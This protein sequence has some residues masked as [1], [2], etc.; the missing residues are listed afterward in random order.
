MDDNYT[1]FS[2]S[3]TI[4]AIK[5]SKNSTAAGP[6]GITMLHLKHIGPLGIRYLTHLFNL[7]VRAADIPALWK[8]ADIIPVPKPG[9]PLDQGTSYRPISLLCPEVKVL[10]RLNLSILKPFLSPSPSQ[11]GFKSN[12][13][14]ISAILPLATEVAR[15]FNAPKPAARTGL[16]CVDLSKAFDV[17]DIHRLLKK[18]DATYLHPN[19]K[20][21][22]C[23][24]LRDRKVRVLYQG[25]SS[26]WRKVKMGVPQGSVLSP[27]L[28][29]FLVNDITSSAPID[30]SFA[31]DFHAAF[32]DVQPSEIALDLESAALELSDQA[33]DHGLSLSAPK[34]TVTL[35]TPWNREF[36][37]LPP[38]TLEGGVIP[39]VNNPRLLGVTFDP[40]FTFSAHAA[41]IARKASSRLNVIRA[42]SDTSFGHDKECLTATFKSLVRP[43]LD[44]AA[45][46][47]FPNYSASSI[48]RLQIIQNRSLRLITGCHSASAIDHL[49]SETEILPVDQHLRLLSAQ[50]LARAL[51]PGHVSHDTVT[52]PSGPRRS[53]ETLQSKC[54][55]LVEPYLQDGVIPPNTYRD[56]LNK[57]HSKVVSDSITNIS[58]N[59]ILN[60]PAPKIDAQESYLPRQCRAVLAQLR[61]GFCAK[62]RNFQYRI[63]GS[64]DDTCPDCQTTAASTNHLFDCT[65]HPTNLTTKALWERP[66][67]AISHISNFQGFNSLPAVGPPPPPRRRHGR[68]PPPEPPPPP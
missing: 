1:P 5:A 41:N 42:L 61:S 66:W 65:S 30:N 46:I 36:G 49:H 44:Y 23:A 2:T 52:L 34:S 7:S 20:R 56:T 31:D 12:H 16:L 33:K 29:N 43:L 57:I 15:G 39:Q 50:Y 48:R 47:V 9:K 62:L 6:N 37:R 13:S 8:S 11:H 55:D 32:S 26:K 17:V 63:G 14:T 22:L 25:K 53:K 58:P 4:D 40:T 64:D 21:W 27:L 45:P 59:R 10:E 18:I 68:R 3:D 54:W 60:A 24:Y 35:F 28:F 67:E 51:Q 38:V 19:M